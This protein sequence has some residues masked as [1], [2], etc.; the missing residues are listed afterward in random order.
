MIATSTFPT[1]RSS[2]PE[3][4]LPISGAV[5]TVA[6][7]LGL[8]VE[9]AAEGI[10]RIVNE[11][12]VGALRLV[13]VEQGYDPR[14]FALIGFGGAGPLHANALARLVNSWPAILPPGPGVL[15]AYGDATTRLRNEASQTF[16]ARVSDTDDRSITAMLKD[17][18]AGAAEALTAEGVPVDEQDVLYQVDIRYHGQ[19]MKLTIDVTPNDLSAT[20]IL[21]ITRRFDSEHEQLFTFALDAEHEIVGLRAVVQG[22]EKSFVT[23]DTGRGGADASAAKVQET[24]IFEGGQWCDAWIYDRAKLKPGNIVQGP[25][26]VTEMDSTSVILPGHVGTIDA[27]GNILIWPEGHE[28]AKG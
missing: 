10:I 25:A 8:S 12:M 21:G 7:A 4:V 26:V 27:I 14:D 15:C 3:D 18:E 1:A 22:A 11:N 5:K 16:V 23:P 13:S 19:G 20:G 9:E 17:L 24:R 28:K 6:D 2:S